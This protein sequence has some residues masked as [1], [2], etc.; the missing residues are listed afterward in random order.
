MRKLALGLIVVV[1]T[2][3][4]VFLAFAGRPTSRGFEVRAYFQDGQGL[5]EGAPVRM[6]GVDVGSVKSVRVRPERRDHQVEVVMRI[7]TSY[8]L[9]IPSD[10]TVGLRQAGILGETFPDIDVRNTTGAPLPYGGTLRTIE[11]EDEMKKFLQGM[12][13]LLQRKQSDSEPSRESPEKKKAR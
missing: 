8:E 10:A 4:A 12:G 11:T 2:A 7:H 9:R 13:N 5:R 6:V 3:G 1:G